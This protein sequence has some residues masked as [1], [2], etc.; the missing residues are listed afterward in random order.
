M[1]TREDQWSPLVQW[2]QFLMLVAVLATLLLQQDP[3]FVLSQGAT[4]PAT[5]PT[6]TEGGS[7]LLRVLGDI[8]DSLV[9]M[10]QQAQEGGIQG[11]L[12]DEAS[13]RASVSKLADVLAQE[14]STALYRHPTNP[15]VNS[16]R[17][18]LTSAPNLQAWREIRKTKGHDLDDNAGAFLNFDSYADVLRRFG[19]PTRMSMNDGALVWYY[20]GKDADGDDFTYLVKFHDGIVI[21]VADW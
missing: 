16:A 19:R 5:P 21:G 13:Y 11:R 1:T 7:E 8:E 3:R 2:G 4:R 18:R 20:E 6:E 17:T 14:I 15:A 10:R 12:L 9:A